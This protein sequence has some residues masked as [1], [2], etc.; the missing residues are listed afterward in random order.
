MVK[1][2]I[3]GLGKMGMLHYGNFNTIENAEVVAAVEPSKKIR[4]YSK[5]IL[6]I[7]VYDDYTKLTKK[8][9]DAAIICVPNKFHSKIGRYYAEQG[10]NIFM[11]KPLTDTVRS[12]TKMVNYAVKH[13]IIHQVGY[14][15][16]FASVFRKGHEFLEQGVLGDIFFVK[17]LSYEG[18]IFKKQKGWRQKDD[19]AGG[20][21][22]LDIGSH[23]M[24]ILYWY[25]GEVK[26]VYGKG[27]NAYSPVD[28]FFS[29]LIE[30]NNGV[31]CNLDTTWSAHG[32]RQMYLELNIEGSNGVMKVT[33]DYIKV[34]LTEA[35]GGLD[36]GWNTIYRVDLYEPTE[37][38]LGV[39]PAF[40]E[41]D[42][43]FIEC[44]RKKKGTEVDWLVGLKIQK[45][46][47]SIKESSVKNQPIKIGGKI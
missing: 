21:A 8:D 28:D 27:K 38:L 47:E 3:I 33:D 41:E 42:K 19:D 1:V 20:G 31:V 34:Y 15:N 36:Q 5:N 44:C 46:L 16:R 30:F 17:A 13:K 25:F 6:E 2:G 4:K 18:L 9:V 40:Y 7:P 39:Q 24:D 11:E 26:S 43:H 35:R 29:A 23:L 12:G 22:L 14:F 32:Y 10:I 37:N 45:I